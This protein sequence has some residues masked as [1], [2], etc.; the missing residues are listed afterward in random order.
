MWAFLEQKALVHVHVARSVVVP[1]GLHV[2]DGASSAC[3]S[4]D[5][6]GRE[7]LRL[8]PELL[9]PR[10]CCPAEEVRL[11]DGAGKSSPAAVHRAVGRLHGCMIRRY[12]EHGVVI[13][14]RSMGEAF[15]VRL[16]DVV[17]KTDRGGR[18]LG[19]GL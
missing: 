9:G 18:S 11:L 5:V 16:G 2:D 1:I 10:I 14:S 7:H 4:C 19:T 3:A 12:A 8:S 13:S 6:F 17:L 15:R